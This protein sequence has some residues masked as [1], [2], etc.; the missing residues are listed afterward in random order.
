VPKRTSITIPRGRVG[1]TA[2]RVAPGGWTA[3]AGRVES[4]LLHDATLALPPAASVPMRIPMPTRRPPPQPYRVHG[5]VGASAGVAEPLRPPPSSNSG[6]LAK[7]IGETVY[8]IGAGINRGVFGPEQ[9]PLPLSRDFFRYVLEQPRFSS[10]HARRQLQPLWEFIDRYWHCG[11]DALRR[12]D[13]DLEECLTLVELQRREARTSGDGER[14]RA[15]SRLEFLLAG[16]LAECFAQVDHWHFFSPDYQKLGRRVYEER[17]AVLTFNYDTLLETAVQHGSPP[18]AG[19]SGVQRVRYS[20]RSVSDD[21]YFPRS[22]NPLLAYKVHFDEVVVKPG[23]MAPLGGDTYYAPFV[24]R[25]SE[26]APFLKLHGSLDWYFRS[27]YTLDGTAI[28]PQ[29]SVSRSRFQRAHAPFDAPEIDHDNSEILLPL[30]LTPTLDAPFDEHPVFRSVWKEARAVLARAK[31][32]I[33][34]G[35]SFPNTDFHVRR[36][37]RE[38]FADNTLEHLHVVNP[39]ASVATLARDLCHFRKPVSVCGDIGEH[40]AG[41]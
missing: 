30:I 19:S 5:E 29:E 16:L 2:P 15:A 10:D 34:I 39:D 40:L 6:A 37:L 35:Y 31:T 27:G 11:Q 12:G 3:T 36:L 23:S 13:F 32:L 20:A 28:D 17:A 1:R 22:W 24:V 33:V 9:R 7:P 21:S 4:P 18:A 8:L 38:A 25:E 26:H 41:R 14:L